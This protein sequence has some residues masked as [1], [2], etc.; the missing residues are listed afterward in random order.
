MSTLSIPNYF[1]RS[2]LQH[3]PKVGLD[4]S[5]LLMKAGIPPE[6]YDNPN[7]GI[8]LTSFATLQIKTM[9][10]MGDEFLGCAPRRFLPGTWS[11]MCH[12]AIH[13]PT[14]GGALTRC[15]NF[16]RM[17][18]DGLQPTLYNHGEYLRIT[19][20]PGIKD[21]DYTLYGW[22][23]M[24]YTLQRFACWL[25]RQQ[26]PSIS[27]EMATPH[28]PHANHYMNI[29]PGQSIRFDCAQFAL[30]VPS[31][32]ANLPLRQNEQSLQH[33][34]RHPILALMTQRQ[35]Q[36]SW[37]V[38]VRHSLSDNIHRSPTINSTAS[39]LNLHPQTLRR[40]LAREGTTY[41]EIKSQCR[42]DA[43]LY[44]LSK[45]KLSIEQI[46]IQIGFSEASAFTRA[47]KHWTG[48]SPQRYRRKLYF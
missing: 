33:F 23:Q 13:S 1:V 10:A 14:L 18:E 7:A 11:N 6:L 48:Q 31:H 25:V 20:E 35:D 34:L 2:V 42:K 21:Y 41:N 46:A 45:P 8:S 19:I 37:S 36:H 12:T 4:R 16:Y 47:F 22:E 3:A 28:P 24:I 26:L 43:A 9:K 40:R 17:F 44:Y 38:R 27:I 5:L 32:V 15:C 29:F 39:D 30:V